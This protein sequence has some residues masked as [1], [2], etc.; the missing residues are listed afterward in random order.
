M[1]D[2]KLTDIF[3]YSSIYFA[4]TLYNKWCLP[5]RRKESTSLRFVAC[6]W[7]K[8]VGNNTATI[9]FVIFV[10]W[11]GLVWKAP[12]I[13]F[14]LL[15]IGTKISKSIVLCT[16]WMKIMS[17]CKMPLN[18]KVMEK[19]INLYES[20]CLY[21]HKDCNFFT[22]YIGFSAICVILHHFFACSRSW[23]VPCSRYFGGGVG[24]WWSCSNSY[25]HG[26][27]D[28]R[29]N[30]CCRCAR[31]FWSKI[32]LIHLTA[33]REQIISRRISS[34]TI[35]MSIYSVMRNFKGSCIWVISSEEMLRR[36][37]IKY[38]SF[39]MGILW[40]LFQVVNIPKF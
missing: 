35:F 21:C 18:S 12:F 13:V 39:K 24:V 5:E 38:V 29:R 40:I 7:V 10:L 6:H 9:L 28:G 32:Q 26:G 14:E 34:F 11:H 2:M 23:A 36:N 16:N 25:S 4:V 33:V 37:D 27:R 8:V 20:S 1:S 17:N 31:C 19:S 22:W 3:G 30:G 15:C